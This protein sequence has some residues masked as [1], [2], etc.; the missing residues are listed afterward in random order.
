VDNIGID[1]DAGDTVSDWANGNRYPSVVGAEQLHAMNITGNGVTVA[2]IDTGYWKH[3]SMDTAGNGASRVLAQY[4][5]I[6]D[7]VDSTG[8]SVNTE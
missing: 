5:A 1:F 4:D 7:I 3:P 8:S 6:R 2:V